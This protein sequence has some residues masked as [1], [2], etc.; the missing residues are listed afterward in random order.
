MCGSG[1][2]ACAGWRGRWVGGEGE[3]KPGRRL[4]PG[5]VGAP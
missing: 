4:K 2:I 3:L 1:S 5:I